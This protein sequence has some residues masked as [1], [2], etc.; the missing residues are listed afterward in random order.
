KTAYGQN[1]EFAGPTFKSL[2]IDGA[3]AIVSFDH[4]DGLMNKGEKILGFEIAGEDGKF[5]PADATIDGEKVIVTADEVKAPKSV[6]YGWDDDPRCTLY[7]G[8]NLPAVPFA[9]RG[10]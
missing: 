7:N 1:V 6:R 3:K 8:A 2:Q 9:T 5:A 4:A 10:K